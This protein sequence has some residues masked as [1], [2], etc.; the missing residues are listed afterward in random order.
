ML[1]TMEPR[2]ADGTFLT[3]QDLIRHVYLHPTRDLAVTHLANEEH[4]IRLLETQLQKKYETR[5]DLCPDRLMETPG[6]NNKVLAYNFDFRKLL[7]R[8]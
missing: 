4:T 5:L 8:K 6:T 7:L 3:Q 2:T 1:F